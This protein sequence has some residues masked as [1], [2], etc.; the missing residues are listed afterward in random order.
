MSKT[1][2]VVDFCS[3]EAAKYAV[4]NWHYSKRMPRS[5]QQFVGVW[6][7]GQFI[8][9]VIFGKSVTP[10]LGKKYQLDAWTS[11][12]LTR[13][14][15]NS[16][17]APVS[18]IVSAAIKLIAT[19]NKGVRLLVSY[20]DP[21]VGHVGGI[22]QAMNWIYVG[23]SAKITQYWFRNQWRND[24]RLFKLFAANPAI[25]KTCPTRILEGKHEYLYPLDRAMRRQIEPLAKPY[26]KKLDM[27]PVNGDN[28]ATS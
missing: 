8:G 16:H 1:K 28:L 3:Y 18:K 6:E 27:P 24:T 5:R 23:K 2:L 9:A 11:A 21:N 7:D 4:M 22:Y 10:H 25:K 13:I 14:A 12:E 20:A 15:L 26:P 17:A 19:K